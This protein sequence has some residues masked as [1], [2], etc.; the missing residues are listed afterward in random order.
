MLDLRHPQDRFHHLQAAPGMDII[1]LPPQRL[2]LMRIV[3]KF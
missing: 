3:Q 1:H 2:A